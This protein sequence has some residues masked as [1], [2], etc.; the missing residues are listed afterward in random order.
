MAEPWPA[1]SY[2]EALAA[3]E[4]GQKLYRSGRAWLVRPALREPAEG[5]LVLWVTDQQTTGD[6]GLL[7]YP[8]GRVK[9]R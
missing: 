8:D 3:Y 2:Q 9:A 1:I 4:A 7:L 5:G 6:S